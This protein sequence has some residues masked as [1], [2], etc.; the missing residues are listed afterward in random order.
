MNGKVY[1]KDLSVSLK[2]SIVLTWIVIGTWLL[3][4][5]IGF[6]IGVT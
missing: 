3:F 4:F 2:T 6:F 1:F 5:L